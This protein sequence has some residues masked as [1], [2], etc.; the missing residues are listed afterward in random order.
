MN[1]KA[2]T[3]IELLVWISI[4]TILML[5]VWYLITGGI[6]NIKS[7]QKILSNV[8]EFSAFQ[9][10]LNEI[11]FNIDTNFKPIITFS[12]IIVKIK[13]N[14]DEWW[15]AYIGLTDSPINNNN[16]I[17][18]LSGSENIHTKHIFIKT[19]IPDFDI[20]IQK[21]H[22]IDW[23]W[24]GIFWHSKI[25]IM[26]LE[27]EKVFLNNP[28]WTVSNWVIKFYSDTLNN[29]ILYNSWAK[30]YKLLWL[31]DWIFE[32]TDLKIFSWDLYIANSGNW[33][34]LKF[35]SK[36]Y[37]TIPNLV[38]TWVTANDSK[39]QIEFYNQ[40][41]KFNLDWTVS[42]DNFSFQNYSKQSWD[43]VY[44]ITNKLIYSFSGW[45]AKSFNNEKIT[46]S[47]LSDFSWTWTYFVKFKMGAFEKYYKYFVQSDDN[48]FTK[49][50]NI[51]EVIKKD[52]T[53]YYNKINWIWS[54]D[55]YNPWTSNLT[56][57]KNYDYILKT[58][59]K[60]LDISWDSTKKILKL[61]LIYYKKYNCYN[62]KDKIENNFLWIKNYLK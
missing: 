23:I 51:L 59:I 4:S 20:D 8:R 21:S 26:W 11:F 25:P 1:K 7:Q 18:C 15:F 42:K 29:R 38:L 30:I 53:K 49:D 19:F 61:D 40:D 47:N 24:K 48:L 52:K 60:K 50:D 27:L 39:F 34:I 17:Y 43:S 6:W 16:W 44:K 12:W 33:E 32:P 13:Q 46:V 45:V 56:Y 36:K 9:N 62:L 37:N 57:D 35:S 41:W 5:S 14:Y 28:T 54:Y 58:P 3:L 10:K 2:F 55:Y 22:K 31:E